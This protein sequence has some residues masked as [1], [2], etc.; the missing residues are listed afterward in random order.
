MTPAFEAAGTASSGGYVDAGD[1]I[2]RTFDSTWN[3]ITTVVQ[4]AGA[5]LSSGDVGALEVLEHLPIVGKH[6][7]MIGKNFPTAVERAP[8]AV[9][10]LTAATEKYTGPMTVG[11][12]DEAAEK[13]VR[14]ITEENMR[15][16]VTAEALGGTR[17]WLV[18][19]NGR[20]ARGIRI[21]DMKITYDTIAPATPSGVRA[22]MG[23][24]ANMMGLD[25][26]GS[27][28]AKWIT[29]THGLPSGEYGGELLEP[30]FF[31][32]ERQFAPV[33]G[34]EATNVTDVSE[35]AIRVGRVDEPTTLNWC[36]SSMS[37]QFPI[38]KREVEE[39]S[40]QLYRAS[41]R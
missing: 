35:Y 25:R 19:P 26:G 34:W 14:P 11:F 7:P 8:V 22:D 13:A 17:I 3:N 41:G 9:E 37:Q 39:T 28:G 5:G 12:F 6:L 24:I 20:E 36:Y 21:R 33:Y 2:Q 27:T 30:L 32:R 31:R 23:A 38:A 16:P 40:L 29:A 15:A 4:F 18:P 1:E 10:Q